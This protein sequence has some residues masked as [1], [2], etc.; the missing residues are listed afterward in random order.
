MATIT[1]KVCDKCGKEIKYKGVTAILVN[2]LKK[3]KAIKIIN[4]YNG[5]Q[6]GLNYTEQIYEL[7]PDC[8][9]KLVEFLR[10]RT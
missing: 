1:K 9:E 4:L 5:N 10:K 2:V 8:T 6:T 3:G 7:C